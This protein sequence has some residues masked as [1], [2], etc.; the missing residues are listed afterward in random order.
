LRQSDFLSAPFSQELI[1]HHCNLNNQ[2]VLS[3]YFYESWKMYFMFLIILYYSQVAV[4]GTQYLH[5][6]CVFTVYLSIIHSFHFFHTVYA[7][8][9]W[10]HPHFHTHTR[11]NNNNR[12]MCVYYYIVIL[13]CVAELT[14]HYLSYYCVTSVTNSTEDNAF[15]SFRCYMMRCVQWIKCCSDAIIRFYVFQEYGTLRDR[16]ARSGRRHH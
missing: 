16:M 2:F 6:L 7:S 13:L 15:F 12:L 9:K 8:L 10:P 3:L 1:V 14:R 11:N 5:L 4:L